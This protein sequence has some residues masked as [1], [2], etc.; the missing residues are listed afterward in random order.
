MP[1]K[2]HSLR[3]LAPDDGRAP[4]TVKIFSNLTSALVRCS[5]GGAH[6]FFLFF[7]SLFVIHAT[8]RRRQPCLLPCHAQDFDQAESLEGVQ[9]VTFSPDDVANVGRVAGG[10][11][12]FAMFLL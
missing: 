3:L 7:P 9:E 10:P 1:V 5:C 2:V 8:A 4:M 11:G 6:F 12:W